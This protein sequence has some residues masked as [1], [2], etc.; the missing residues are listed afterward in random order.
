MQLHQSYVVINDTLVPS[1]TA[2]LLIS[3]VLGDHPVSTRV[4]L[5]PEGLADR[6]VDRLLD[7]AAE[8]GITHEFSGEF[9]LGMLSRLKK[10]SDN[11]NRDYEL[12]LAQGEQSLL[13]IAALL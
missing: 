4:I 1:R 11:D 6:A 5:E 12:R 3:R 7:Q 10:T 9:I 2:H 8:H 13:Y